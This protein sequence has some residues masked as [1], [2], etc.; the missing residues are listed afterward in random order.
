[1]VKRA[2]AKL[3]LEVPECTSTTPAI[4]HPRD[5]WQNPKLSGRIR[6]LD[7]LRGLAILLVLFCHYVALGI[8]RAALL[9]WQMYVFRSLALTASGVDL[10][11]VLSGFLIGGILYDAKS[12]PNYF[13]AFY[14]RR[15]CRIFP[16]YFLWI[17]LFIIGL[18]VVEHTA[19]PPG[20]VWWDP[21]ALFNRDL[22]LWSYPLFLQNVAIVLHQGFGPPWTTITWSL[23][24]E[25]QF[26][27]LLPILVRKLSYRH[28]AYV[29][30]ASIVLAPASRLYLWFH[31][32][33]LYG[34]AMLLPCR[35]ETFGLGVLAALACRNKTVWTWLGSHRW[36]LYCGLVISSSGFFLMVKYPAMLTG[37]PLSCVALFYMFL[38]LLAVVNPSRLESVCL[39]NNLLVYLG[40]ISYAVYLFHMGVDGLVHLAIFGEQQVSTSLSICVSVLTIGIVLPL[41]ALSWRFLEK[42]IISYGHKTFRHN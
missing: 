30:A 31:G 33:F 36:L 10:F 37:P 17:G 41:A 6:E 18:F 19:K 7:G 11:F 28:L 4:D 3:V 34:P 23:A 8:S 27:V 5:S 2:T 20:A 21:H 14:G 29:A 39:G 16:L 35:A 22:P 42:P 13:R 9:P 1:M 26:Y 40:V 32:E 24:V 38:L 15:F 25:E 12:S